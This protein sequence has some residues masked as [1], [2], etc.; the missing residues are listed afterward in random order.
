MGLNCVKLTKICLGWAFRYKSIPLFWLWL[1]FFKCQSAAFRTSVLLSPEMFS[2]NCQSLY[3]FKKVSFFIVCP[4]PG[5]VF[6]PSIKVNVSLTNTSC[7][8]VTVECFVENSKELT[9]SLYRGRDRLKSTSSSV[10]SSRLSLALEIKS[11]DGDDYSCVAENPVDKKATKIHTEDTCLR[12]GGMIL[13]H[14][15]TLIL[16]SLY[17]LHSCTV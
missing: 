13:K 10:L 15:S 7:S 2:T 14:G 4:S 16:F 12:D 3:L 5:S 8:S 6:P 9:L 17:A 11:H 1:Y